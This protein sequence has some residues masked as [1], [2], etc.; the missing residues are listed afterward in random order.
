MTCCSTSCAAAVHF[1]PKKGERDLRRYQRRG[2]DRITRLLLAELRRSPL[3]GLHLLDVGSGIGVIAAELAGDGLT[4]VTLADASPAYLDVARH[5]VG[6]RY[7]SRPVQFILGDFTETGAG[8]PDADIV[9]LDRVVCCY[10]DAKALLRLAA[11]RS[12]RLPSLILAISGSSAPALSWRTS[13]S[14]HPQPLPRLP[15]LPAALGFHPGGRR[16]RPS[17]ASRNPSLGP[18]PLPPRL[19][20]DSP[21]SWSGGSLDLPFPL[22]VIPSEAR[23]LRHCAPYAQ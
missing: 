15:S 8:L 4:G 7:S 10:P 9:T 17:R 2:P 16:L 5:H 12:R 11:T 3:A 13:V 19:L 14:P 1:D 23:S 22:P 21:A 18:R 20:K 6:P